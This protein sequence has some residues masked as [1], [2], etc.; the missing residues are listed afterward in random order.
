[1]LRLLGRGLTNAE[2]ATQL[3]MMRGADAILQRTVDQARQLLRADSARID[4]VERGSMT[5]RWVFG[6][7]GTEDRFPRD[8]GE[9][10]VSMSEGVS[11]LALTEVT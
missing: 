8:E 4:L 7:E 5:M 2:I 1:M 3:T 9:E 10:I 6:S 11:G